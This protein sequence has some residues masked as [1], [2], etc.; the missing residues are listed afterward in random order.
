MKNKFNFAVLWKSNFWAINLANISSVMQISN[1]DKY[2]IKLK[3]TERSYDLH[4]KL[5]YYLATR[6][7]Q[8]N[9]SYVFQQGAVVCSVLLRSVSCFWACTCTDWLMIVSPA[10]PGLCSGV[11]LW[12]PCSCCIIQQQPDSVVHHSQIQR[13]RRLFVF[14]IVLW[15]AVFKCMNLIYMTVYSQY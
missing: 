12:P 2:H 6:T 1:H 7:L 9:N 3:H 14:G 15:T 13:S 11:L 4:M 8:F 5:V 10:S